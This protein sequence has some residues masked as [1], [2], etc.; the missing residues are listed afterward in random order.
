[1][2]PFIQPYQYNIIVEQATIVVQ[3]QRSVN[4][5]HTVDTLKLLAL[6]KIQEAFLE[7]SL[8]EK[9]LLEEAITLGKTQ[10]EL[11]RYLMK[12]KEC[13]I[14]FKQPS[15]QGVQKVF[16]KTKKLKFPEWEEVDL[17]RQ[18][19]HG[20]NDIAKQRK[21]LITYQEGKLV[22][23]QGTISPTI[24]KGLCAICQTISEVSMFEAKGKV[25]KEGNYLLKGNYICHDSEK[26]NHQIKDTA[27]LDR[28]IKHISP[29]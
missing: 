1:M 5:R 27:D 4:D 29:K 21:Y 15:D 3:T 22:G 23:L 2:N 7:S 20:W 18:T 11:D 26:C 12:V 28:F 8:E 19:F 14:P 16:A 9:E 13:I 25:S 24:K 17:S 6:E 10:K